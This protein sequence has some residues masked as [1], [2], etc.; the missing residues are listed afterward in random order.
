MR[1]RH[2]PI[3]VKIQLITLVG[4]V[5]AMS[6]GWLGWNAI[7]ATAQTANESL[8]KSLL[9]A[10]AAELRHACELAIDLMRHE[11]RGMDAAA[12]LKRTRELL[13]DLY[14]MN[15]PPAK[16]SGY[17]FLYDKECMT[18]VLPPSR[19]VEGTSRKDFSL[20]GQFLV[21]DFNAVAAKGGRQPV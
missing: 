17:F 19:Q 4:F 18:L 21:R 6:I 8:R 14:F 3:M 10:R 5:L 16:P 15:N 1:Y 12:R 13:G 11:T 9:D 2:W 7:D 20:G